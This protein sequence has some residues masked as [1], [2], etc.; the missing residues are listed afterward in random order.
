[1]TPGRCKIL[2]RHEGVVLEDD[3]GPSVWVRLIV[4]GEEAEEEFEAEI[5]RSSFSEADQRVLAPG[6]LFRWNI[7]TATLV[8]GQQVNFSNFRVL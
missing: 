5:P 1:M 3:G 2:R 7:G 8:H 6:V 4:V